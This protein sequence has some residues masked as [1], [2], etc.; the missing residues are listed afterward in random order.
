MPTTL[1]RTKVHVAIVG[2][3]AETGKFI[4]HG[5][6]SDGNFDITLLVCPQS[7]SKPRVQ[8][9]STSEFAILPMDSSKSID[10]DLLRSFNII[11]SAVDNFGYTDQT[12][13]A[14]TAKMASVERFIP[15]GFSTISPPGDVMHLRDQKEAAYNVTCNC[16]SGTPLLISDSSISYRICAYHAA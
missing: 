6:V 9:L 10:Q 14:C 11:I 1:G 16:N 12:G 3:T 13:I 15:C 4:L 2:A 7:I 8:V 5:L